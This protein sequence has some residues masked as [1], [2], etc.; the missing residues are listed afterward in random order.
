MG[1]I[2]IR[3][4]KTGQEIS[5]GIEIEEGELQRLPPVESRT[6]CLLCGD[7][8]PWHPQHARVSDPLLSDL[9]AKFW[10]DGADGAPPPEKS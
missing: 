9:V 8:H 10:A 4:P 6:Y 7:T 2:V 5:T 1:V 3:C